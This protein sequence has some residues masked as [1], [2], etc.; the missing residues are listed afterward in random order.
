LIGVDHIGI[1]ADYDGVDLMPVGVEDVASYPELFSALIDNGWNTEELV[2]L[3]GANILR[4]IRDNERVIFFIINIYLIGCYLLF[5]NNDSMPKLLSTL[6]R[7]VVL[8]SMLSIWK[9]THT[10]KIMPS[11]V[12]IK[13]KKKVALKQFIENTCFCI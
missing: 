3:A 12:I 1:G 4:V 9:I 6:N 11:V 7:L 13:I 2:K 10:V 5:L 8:K